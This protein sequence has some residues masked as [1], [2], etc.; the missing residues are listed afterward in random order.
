MWVK[1]TVI[2]MLRRVVFY[3]I[4]LRSQVKT[5]RGMCLPPIVSDVTR[6][7]TQLKF[8]VLLTVY[9]YVSQ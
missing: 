4:M 6:K 7:I 5:R 2:V 1:Y 8:D 9:H 3:V